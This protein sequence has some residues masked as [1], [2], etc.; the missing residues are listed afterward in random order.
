MFLY[1]SDIML[2]YGLVSV[3]SVLTYAYI[4]EDKQ[5]L[6]TRQTWGFISL[7]IILLLACFTFV[8]WLPNYISSTNY[9]QILSACSIATIL[10]ITLFKNRSQRV[11][12]WLYALYLFVITISYLPFYILQ[13]INLV[14]Y[15]EAF[16]SQKVIDKSLGYLFST[17]S[18]IIIMVLIANLLTYLE[19][20][21]KQREW[22]FR[23]IPY[24]IILLANFYLFLYNNY[25]TLRVNALLKSTF[26]IQNKQA[27]ITVLWFISLLIYPI[28]LYKKHRIKETDATLSLAKARKIKAYHRSIRRLSLSSIAVIS[29]TL[30]SMTI[31]PH[32]LN[33]EP[34]LS[35]PESFIE[36]D[37]QIKIPLDILADEKLHRFE[38]QDKKGNYARFI[39]IKKSEYSYGVGLDA[40]RICGASG[41]YQRGDDVV[42]KLCDVV[43]N[44]ATIG[45]EGGCNPIPVAFHLD[46]GN[47]V[48]TKEDL[49]KDTDIFK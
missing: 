18:I 14:P 43:M 13:W 24:L 41:Y 2:N 9:H 32:V 22:G 20:K 40:C 28:I 21:I 17:L 39:A 23:L 7:A 11:K 47:I 29:L 10:L 12:Q 31:L 49:L 15:G 33:P 34:V 45:F 16:I 4:K 35:D 30:L 1:Y 5:P 38:Y 6:Y 48:I 46:Q 3:F 42:C 37:D 36:T 26:F 25:P 19:E 27:L 44:K 8:L